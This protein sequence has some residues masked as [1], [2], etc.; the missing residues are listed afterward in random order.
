MADAAAE[1][2]DEDG[3][4]DRFERRRELRDAH[5][6]RALDAQLLAA[7]AQRQHVEGVAG[8]GLDPADATHDR[9]GLAAVARDVSVGMDAGALAVALGGAAPELVVLGRRGRLA[10]VA[11]DQLGRIDAEQSPG[12]AVGGDDAQAF[13]LDQAHRLDHRLDERRP[14]PARRFGDAETVDRQRV[15]HSSSSTAFAGS[16]KYETR[17]LGAR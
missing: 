9:H 6:G 11:S 14:R 15:V 12:G 10:H 2:D 17:V 1:V 3:V 7:I 5:L 16:K 13:R 8:R 4:A